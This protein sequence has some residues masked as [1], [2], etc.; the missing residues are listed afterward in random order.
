V[1][2]DRT[3]DYTFQLES[4][5]GAWL[6]IDGVLL[7][8]NHGVH[9]KKAVYSAAVHLAAGHHTFKARYFYTSKESAWCHVPVNGDGRWSEPPC[10]R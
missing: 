10:Y 4:V 2:L 1:S 8:D 9:P 6:W 7:A 5:D 3:G